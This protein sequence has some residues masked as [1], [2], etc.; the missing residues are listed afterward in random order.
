MSIYKKLFE[1]QK[2]IGTISKSTTNPFFK[3]KYFDIN[4]LI[5]HVQPLLE[6]HGLLLTQPISNGRVYSIIHDVGSE[7]IDFTE[8]SIDLPQISDP[9]KLGSAITYYRRYTL[10]SLLALQAEDDD[11]NKASRSEPKQPAK[12]IL[13]DKQ[14]QSAL[15]G[16]KKQIKNVLASYEL[17]QYKRQELEK[18][19]K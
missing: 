5:E 14:Y 13:S 15:K 10:A 2:E 17:S 8:S 11:G 3:S 7:K 9:Q 19:I 6:K 12:P 18:L 16:T 4:A 1:L